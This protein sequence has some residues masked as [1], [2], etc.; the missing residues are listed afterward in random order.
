MRATRYVVASGIK[1]SGERASHWTKDWMLTASP[2]LQSRRRTVE[3][4][5]RAIFLV[6]AVGLACA[7]HALVTNLK[8]YLLDKNKR[9]LALEE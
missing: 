5:K 2:H 6:N 7:R 3:K 4:T 9:K 8:K 1:R